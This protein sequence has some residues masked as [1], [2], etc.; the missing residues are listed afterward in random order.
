MLAELLK[1]GVI[2]PA[3]VPAVCGL[4]LWIRPMTPG[5][6]RLLAAAG[7]GLGWLAAIFL[8]GL[9]PFL[10]ESAQTWHWLPALVVA[11]IIAGRMPEAWPVRLVVA[12]LLGALAGYV[13]IPDWESVQPHRRQLQ[14]LLGAAVF[15]MTLLDRPMRTTGGRF[16]TLLLA[17]IAGAAGALLELG[18]TGIFAQM[19][20]A[21]AA[22]LVGISFC[23]HRP[24]VV[25]GYLP[26]AAMLL[27]SVLTLG[28]L[29]SYSQVPIACYVMAGAA[30]LAFALPFQ[31]GRRRMLVQA[32]VVV[33]LLM[34]AV[35]WAYYAEPID[36]QALRETM[37]G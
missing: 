22:A 13:L 7:V 28:C 34:A 14:V 27:S 16:S 26:V 12:A 36:W 33:L 3:A 29:N 23:G 5:V 11:A 15:V 25:A 2:L 4:T 32:A 17:V 31:A 9:V 18:G 1:Y 37:M 21:L 10:P 35:G 30:P 20:G 24:G 19:A 6:G 8:L